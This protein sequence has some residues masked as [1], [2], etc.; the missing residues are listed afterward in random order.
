[1]PVAIAWLTP[2]GS[3]TKALAN[4]EEAA[5]SLEDRKGASVTPKTV[6]DLAR[7]VFMRSYGLTNSEIAWEFLAKKHPEI[8][9]LD[10]AARERDYAKEHAREMS[11]LR[12]V[13]S[14]GLESVTRIVPTLSRF[15][16]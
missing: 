7:I 5:F 9:S 10:D 1:M 8:G 3:K 6:D 12:Q 13:R 2:Y 11:R 14:R 4:F 16:D 15:E